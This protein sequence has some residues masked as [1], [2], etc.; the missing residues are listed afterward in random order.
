[1]KALFFLDVPHRLAG[2]QRSLLAAVE[3][4]PALGVEPLIV[5]PG[6]GMCLDAFGALGLRTLV[7]P[8]PE[9]LLVFGKKL[10]RVDRLTWARIHL[11]EVLPYSRRVAQLV[12]DEAVDVLHFNTPR[13][14][15][16]AGWAAGL[17]D[18]P[19]VLHLR[20][21]TGFVGPLWTLGQALADRIIIVA[22]AVEEMIDPMFRGGARVVYN[23]ITVPGRVDREGAKARLAQALGRPLDDTPLF[24]SLS[25]IVPFKGLHHL[26]EA[27]ALAKQRGLRARYV[28]AGDGTPDGYPQWLRRRCTQLGLDDIVDFLGFVPD[29]LQILPA[30]DA[31]VLP[32][33]DRE[34]LRF[35]GRELDIRGSE[36]L[37]RSVL[38]AMSV[39]L[40]VIASHVTGTG[41]QV[42]DGV[43]GW[44]VPPGDPPALAERLC[45]VAADPRWR[46]EAGARGRAAVGE[47]FSVQQASRGLRD[48][49]EEVVR[50]RRA[51]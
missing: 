29:P 45:Q 5:A 51:G 18:R 15:L 19:S 46:V 14:I 20:G 30:A 48:V 22:R 4:L 42:E 9:S 8:A 41:E 35:D 47:K 26:L 23:G 6:P 2:S 31:L 11:G 43:T 40:P 38:E 3:G 24:V 17:S 10:L 32:S 1:M 33:I 49:L 16:A 28:L 39:G 25:S 13:G 21:K 12:R 7:L 27:A 36:G 44:L 50:S 37:P 34:R